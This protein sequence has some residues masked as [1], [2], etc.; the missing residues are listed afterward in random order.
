MT[1]CWIDIDDN[2]NHQ[3]QI[4][5]TCIEQGDGTYADCKTTTYEKNCQRFQILV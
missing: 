4:C 3:R 1:Y 2:S 5:E